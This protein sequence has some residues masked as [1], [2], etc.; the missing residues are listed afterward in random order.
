MVCTREE[1]GVASPMW[2]RETGFWR[3]M[4]QETGTRT[5]KAPRIPWTMTNRVRPMPLKKPTQQKK[6]AVSMQSKA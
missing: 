4:I 1:A 3:L 2:N 5:Q 6:I